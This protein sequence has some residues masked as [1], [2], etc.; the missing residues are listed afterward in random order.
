[1]LH[2]TASSPPDNC[3]AS[4]VIMAARLSKTPL[5]IADAR[6]HGAPLLFANDA[7]AALV[8]V[9]ATTLAGRPVTTLAGL[10]GGAVEPGATLRFQ[11]AQKN[12]NSFPAALSIAAVPG[13]DGA[14]LCLLCSLVDARGEGADAAIA[15]DAELLAQVALAAGDLMRESAVAAAIGGAD[16]RAAT[17]SGIALGAVERATHIAVQ[18][19]P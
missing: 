19:R 7:F 18:H 16:D 13:P 11:L 1:M 5:A 10:P 8:D 12:G 14:P 9:D 6:A 4:A 2:F 17:A 15:R 3:P